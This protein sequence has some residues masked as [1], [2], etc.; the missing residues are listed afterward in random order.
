MTFIKAISKLAKRKKRHGY[1]EASE[2]LTSEEKQSI[3]I[4]FLS[5][6]VPL[7]V[8]STILLIS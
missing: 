3:L 7:V 1:Y 8:A 5:I 4:V 2:I 6:C